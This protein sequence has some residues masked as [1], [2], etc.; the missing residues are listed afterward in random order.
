MKF[1]PT[2]CSGSFSLLLRGDW[3][4]KEGGGGKEKKKFTVSSLS[5]AELRREMVVSLPMHDQP[6]RQLVPITQGSAMAGCGVNL[7]LGR[8]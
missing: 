2:V 8:V 1:L 7:E 3:E 6:M 5:P 4:P